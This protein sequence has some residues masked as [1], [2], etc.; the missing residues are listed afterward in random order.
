MIV[1]ADDF[2]LTRGVNRGVIDC[3]KNGILRSASLLANGQALDHAIELSVSVAGLDLGIHLCLTD[4]PPVFT[5]FTG[6]LIDKHGRFFTSYFKVIKRISVIPGLISQIKGEFRCQIEHILKKNV[7]LSH[8]NSHKHLHIYPPLWKIVSELAKEYQIPYMRYPVED[9]AR[10]GYIFWK[11]NKERSYKEL[12]FFLIYFAV[13][14]TSHTII[15]TVTNVN[16]E[17]NPSIH[18]NLRN[19]RLPRS[20]G[21]WYWGNLRTKSPDFFCGLFD[22]GFLDEM[23][24]IDHIVRLRPGVTELMCHPGYVDKA[25]RQL[26]TRLI[27]SREKE[28]AAL[29]SLKV[30]Q[31]LRDNDIKVISFNECC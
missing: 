28:V 13:F 19:L 16:G 14:K 6:N 30:K 31:A 22:T 3:Y 4:L 7:A 8:I 20:S 17:L 24:I 12:S 18:E 1:C 26:P 29:C 5:K 15:K 27:H 21:R 25:L 10:L 9:I 2:G 11:K 23:S